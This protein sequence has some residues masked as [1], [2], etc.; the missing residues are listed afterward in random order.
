MSKNIFS[1]ASAST[2]LLGIALAAGCVSDESD[3][4]TATDSSEQALQAG[5]NLNCTVTDATYQYDLAIGCDALGRCTLNR[6]ALDGSGTSGFPL[7]VLS[8]RRG[9][10]IMSNGQAGV[11]VLMSVL[12]SV[13]QAATVYSIYSGVLANCTKA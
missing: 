7:S 6:T 11:K 3:E 12:G 8:A 10:V 4:A 2:F 1:I 5:G 13:P 9:L